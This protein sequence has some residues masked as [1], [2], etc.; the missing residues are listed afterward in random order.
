MLRRLA[1]VIASVFIVQSLLVHAQTAPDA[2]SVS[3][4][5]AGLLVLK[6]P[7]THEE[8]VHAVLK[9]NGA[10]LTGTAGPD[11]DRQYRI[12]NGKVATTK[13]A[14]V[15][16]F[17]VIVNGVHTAFDLKLVSGTLKGSAL[18]EG[19]DG[20]RHTATV[21]LKRLGPP[22]TM[23]LWLSLSTSAAS[24]SPAPRA[25]SATACPSAV[26][27]IAPSATHLSRPLPSP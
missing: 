3:G 6:V 24:L 5:W 25:A 9:Q 20:Q 4:A 13:D 7:E 8:P 10:A 12:N 18:V 27:R 15:V 19:E 11:A 17:D 22:L 14:M 2:Q 23:D 26:R 16:S 21:E 1:I